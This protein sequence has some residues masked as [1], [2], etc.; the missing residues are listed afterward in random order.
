MAAI[1]DWFEVEVTEA[2]VEEAAVVIAVAVVTA[3]TAVA[4][5]SEHWPVVLIE[6]ERPPLIVMGRSLCVHQTAF[7]NSSWPVKVSTY[8][9]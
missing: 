8:C 3:A 4:V 6:H 2:V 9:Y 5:V 7:P 1:I